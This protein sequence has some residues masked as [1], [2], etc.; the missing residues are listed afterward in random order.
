MMR[1]AETRNI[2]EAC[3]LSRSRKLL[4]SILKDNKPIY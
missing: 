4:G 2:L 1:Q 3:L